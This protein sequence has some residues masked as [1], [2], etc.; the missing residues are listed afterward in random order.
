MIEFTKG[1]M[2]NVPVDARVN[3]VNCVGVMGTGVALAFKTRYPDM[4]KDYERACRDGRVRPGTLHIWKSLTGDWVINFPTKRDWQDPSRYEDVLSGLE[5]LRIYLSRQGSIS[6]AL[7]ALGCGHGGLEWDKVSAMIKDKLGDLEARI[8]VFE[9]QDSRDAGRAIRSQTSEEERR[10]LKE[11][12]FGFFHL[13]HRQAGRALPLTI[14]AKGEHALLERPW[15]ALLP[16]RDPT[17]REMSALEAVARQMSS[18]AESVPVAF[19]YATRSAERIAKLF[20][21]QGVPVVLILPFGPLSWKSV[22]RT[23]E[24]SLQAPLVIVSL[25]A[26]SQPWGRPILAE[27]MKLLKEKACSVLLTDP[28]PVWLNERSARNWS[29]RSTFYLLY[30]N[31]SEATLRELHEIGARPIGRR[32]ETGEPNLANLFVSTCS[33]KRSAREGSSGSRTE[34]TRGPQGS[35]ELRPTAEKRKTVQREIRRASEFGRRLEKLIGARR[36]CPT[37]DREVLLW[38]YWSL[39][40]DFHKGILLL[41]TDGLAG[42]AFGLVSPATEALLNARAVLAGSADEVHKTIEAAHNVNLKTIRSHVDAALDFADLH[43][44]LTNQTRDI[45]HISPRLSTGQPIWNL[46]GAGLRPKYSDEEILEVIRIVTTATFSVT[47]LI[48]KHLKL[49]AEARVTA[50][51]FRNWRKHRKG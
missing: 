15:V 39:I 20:L 49:E 45:P 16:S 33:Q 44:N 31:L 6:V 36:Q 13:P 48:T 43:E 23:P 28:D 21:T 32:P 34:R 42:S 46:G 1:N 50:E 9:P 29:Q 17:E 11:L 51:L 47:N 24:G 10:A 40:F 37:D 12:E 8:L 7:P 30:D 19:L 5:A 27:S 26:P 35:V 22:A 38:G 3:T 14:L 18:S 25:A 2:F 4:F 41:L